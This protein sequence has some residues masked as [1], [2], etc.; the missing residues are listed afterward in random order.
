MTMIIPAGKF[1]AKC[2]KLMD[3]VNQTREEVVI[4][5]RGKPIAKLVP[6]ER[7]GVKKHKFV[8]SMAGTV[9]ILGDIVGPTG[10]TWDA[11]R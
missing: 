4:T 3:E 6:T 1:K 7:L 10:E 11:E 5:K 2:L 9:R 8:G